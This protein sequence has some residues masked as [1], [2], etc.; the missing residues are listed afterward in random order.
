MLQKNEL[1]LRWLKSE[2]DNKRDGIHLNESY[3]GR[4]L[5]QSTHV[6]RLID[7]IIFVEGIF[8]RVNGNCYLDSLIW[9]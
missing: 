1:L 3:R 5:G 6:W 8:V 4:S 7:L 9:Q 2:G